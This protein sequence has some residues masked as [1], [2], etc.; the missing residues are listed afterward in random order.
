MKASGIPNYHKHYFLGL[1]S[2]YVSLPFWNLSI[3]QKTD[4]LV[5]SIEIELEL[6]KGHDVMPGLLLLTLQHGKKLS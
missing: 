2:L 3:R 6:I 5:I 4:H 1:D